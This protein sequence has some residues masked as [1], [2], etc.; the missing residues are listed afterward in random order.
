MT[1]YQTNLNAG[2]SLVAIVDQVSDE[3]CMAII[4]IVIFHIGEENKIPRVELVNELR[5]QGFKEDERVI[6]EAISRLRLVYGFP[7][8][9]TGGI[10]GGYWILKNDEEAKAYLKV[11]L[12]TRAMTILMQ[13]SAI[14]KS[15]QRWYPGSQVAQ[16]IDLKWTEQLENGVPEHK[17]LEEIE[18]EEIY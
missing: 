5:S 4:R 15:F 13:E 9:G 6:R 16:K 10:N 2:F 7:I 1:T 18:E 17:I 8:A 11:E 14:R 3:L 12:H